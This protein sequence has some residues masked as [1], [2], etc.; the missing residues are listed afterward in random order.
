MVATPAFEVDNA[1]TDRTVS[2][3]KM[4]APRDLHLW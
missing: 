1:L 4:Q 2:W 3:Y